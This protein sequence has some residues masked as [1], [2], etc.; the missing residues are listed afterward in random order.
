MSRPLI[1]IHRRVE[2]FKVVLSGI[3]IFFLSPCQEVWV[4]FDMKD[5]FT[6]SIPAA[7]VPSATGQPSQPS[8]PQIANKEK[9]ESEPSDMPNPPQPQPQTGG[10]CVSGSE[11]AA[12]A[13]AELQNFTV[14]QLRKKSKAPGCDDDDDDS[15]PPL[16]VALQEVLE[17]HYP[18]YKN[19]ENTA[20]MDGV[21]LLDSQLSKMKLESELKLKSVTSED[22]VCDMRVK[23]PNASLFNP[24]DC[25]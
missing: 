8:Q 19:L 11:A 23:F 12:D 6:I 7:L 20:P 3:F 14:N 18:E 5:T 21:A 24:V 10:T 22:I 1:C 2:Q 13:A 9:A 15:G 17:E 25:G 16:E 4:R